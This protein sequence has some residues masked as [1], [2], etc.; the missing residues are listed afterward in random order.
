M[1]LTWFKMEKFQGSMS[2]AQ[3]N[4]LGTSSEGRRGTEGTLKRR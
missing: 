1:Y 3:T 2:S 4:L